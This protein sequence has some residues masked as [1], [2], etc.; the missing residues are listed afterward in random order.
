[1]RDRLLQILADGLPH[2]VVSTGRNVVSIDQCAAGA[3]LRFEDGSEA[4]PFDLVV[5][6]DGIKGAARTAVRGGGKE[7]GRSRGLAG[8]KDTDVAIYSG[9]RI[10]FGV[11]RASHRPEG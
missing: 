3:T 5:G 10:Q 7:E 1:M 11:A 4:G 9:I 6:A 2:G 8:R